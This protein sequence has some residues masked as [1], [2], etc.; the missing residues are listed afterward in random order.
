MGEEL[1]KFRTRWRR[2]L[3]N[4]TRIGKADWITLLDS[5]WLGWADKVLSDK[6]PGYTYHEVDYRSTREEVKTLF[7][8][9]I[10]LYEMNHLYRLDSLYVTDK[11]KF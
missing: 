8:R 9:A 11:M 3:G 6:E 10:N 4:K 7:S 2:W 1:E 5:N